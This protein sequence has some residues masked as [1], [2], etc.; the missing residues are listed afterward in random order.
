M[1][2]GGPFGP[3]FCFIPI[4]LLDLLQLDVYRE[5]VAVAS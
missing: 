1:Q 2:K 4:R 3:P 5:M